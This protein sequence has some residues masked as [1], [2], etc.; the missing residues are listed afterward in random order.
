VGGGHPPPQEPL[1]LMADGGA[2]SHGSVD[3]AWQAITAVDPFFVAL[4]EEP[5]HL[6]ELRCN[7]SILGQARVSCRRCGA[8]VPG[9]VVPVAADVPCYGWQHPVWLEQLVL[10]SHGGSS[11]GG[12]LHG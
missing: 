12:H 6:L 11:A 2:A 7:R 9:P 10:S 5:I 8:S 3:S 1:V 4:R